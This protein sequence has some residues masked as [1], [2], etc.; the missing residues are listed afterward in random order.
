MYHRERIKGRKEKNDTMKK[1][2]LLG[3]VSV[4]SA[5]P[6]FST[7]CAKSQDTLSDRV[8]NFSVKAEDTVEIGQYYTPEVPQA[9]VDGKHA[10]VSVEA[11]QGD[12]KLFFNGDNALL[13][14]NFGD[15][16]ITYTIA[17]GTQKLTK[18]TTLK[19]QDTTEPYIVTTLPDVMYYGFALKYESYIRIGDLSGDLSEQAIKITDQNGTPIEVENGSI[20][21]SEESGVEE[22]TFSMTAKDGKNNESAKSVTLPV[23]PPRIFGSSILEMIDTGNVTAYDNTKDVKV[24][25][26]AAT[27]K[28][29][30][31]FTVVAPSKPVAGTV[32]GVLIDCPDWV[33]AVANKAYVNVTMEVVEQTVGANKRGWY[34]GHTGI[35]F[36][37]VQNNKIA[38]G[39]GDSE[40]FSYEGLADVQKVTRYT[41]PINVASLITEEG[42]LRLT[43]QTTTGNTT[44]GTIRITDIQFGGFNKVLYPNDS[45]N[46][47]VNLL[48]HLGIKERELTQLTFTP[49][50]GETV[51][52]PDVKTFKPTTGGVLNFKFQK[53]GYVE[54][55][56]SSE[57]IV[58]EP[59][60][61]TDGNAGL[62]FNEILNIYHSCYDLIFVS[63]SGET[64]KITDKNEKRNQQ[65]TESGKYEIKVKGKGTVGI[66]EG[67][68]ICIDV[69]VN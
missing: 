33:N 44:E 41:M 55:E 22:V 1:K 53:Y 27:N 32:S 43:V 69:T 11:T 14:E 3:I 46:N 63:E 38:L 31:E 59:L 52:V 50:G 4:L 37:N 40:S 7:A 56:A 10:F 39:G 17:E 16:T 35:Y 36:G 67:T 29:A 58:F 12:E 60:T 47:G 28:Q 21:V 49:T 65:P 68:T 64:T 30:I 42:K 48:D 34:L 26:D 24:V 18:S 19:V 45:E 8:Q 9:T 66:G 5:I 57:V 2:K 20:M 13:V 6:L 61:Y 62:N 54:Y 23:L 51:S 15:I 25:K